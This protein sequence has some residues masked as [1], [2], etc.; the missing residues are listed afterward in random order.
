MMTAGVGIDL[1][2]VSR[3]Q[4]LLSGHNKHLTKIFTLAEIEYCQNKP[5]QFQHLAARLA[6]KEAVVKAL[7]TGWV[8]GLSGQI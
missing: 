8:G 5:H 6:V 4:R 3:V 2:K 7:G 1:V